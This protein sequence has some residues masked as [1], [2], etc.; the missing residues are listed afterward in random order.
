M[1]RIYDTLNKKYFEFLEL[2]DSVVESYKSNDAMMFI[3]DTDHISQIDAINQ[4]LRRFIKLENNAF[5]VDWSAVKED[6]VQQFKARRPEVLN[7]LDGEYFKVSEK[8]TSTIDQTALAGL[9][10]KRTE[11][12]NYKEKWRNLSDNIYLDTIVDWDSYIAS[13]GLIERDISPFD[14]PDPSEEVVSI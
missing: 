14:L 13:F 7:Y 11:I 8:I 9:Y 5:S 4:G 10:E 6:V 12:V 1:I 2:D 3:E